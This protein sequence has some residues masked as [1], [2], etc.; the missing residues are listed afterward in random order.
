MVAKWNEMI[1]AKLPGGRACRKAIET[2]HHRARLASY[3]VLSQNGYGDDDDDDDDDDDAAD[4]HF[5]K[6]HL[7]CQSKPIAEISCQ[8]CS[9]AVALKALGDA[10]SLRGSDDSHAL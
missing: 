10:S 9:V 8:P 6:Q 5:A 3:V 2:K 7:R 4:A 1:P